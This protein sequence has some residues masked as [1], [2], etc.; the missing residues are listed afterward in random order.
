MRCSRQFLLQLGGDGVLGLQL[1]TNGM[2]IK[3]LT[4]ASRTPA[5]TRMHL[6]CTLSCKQSSGT[7]ILVWKCTPGIVSLRAF[8]QIKSNDVVVT[9]IYYRADS[10]SEMNVSQ[11]PMQRRAK[12]WCNENRKGAVDPNLWLGMLP[13]SSPYLILHWLL[14]WY[15]SS[16]CLMLPKH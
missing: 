16:P 8:E 13:E 5:I 14:D 2:L 7:E 1:N 3:H 4:S 11:R 15:Y 6:M 12:I 9:S 10:D